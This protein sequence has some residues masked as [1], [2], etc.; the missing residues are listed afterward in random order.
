MK[1]GGNDKALEALKG[2][3][4]RDAKSKYTSRQMTAYKER[5]NRLVQEDA[6]KYPNELVLEGFE[7]HSVQSAAP[8]PEPAQDDFFADWGTDPALRA[9]T[10]SARPSTSHAASGGPLRFAAPG[11]SVDGTSVGFAKH[12][13]SANGFG[14]KPKKPEPSPMEMHEASHGWNAGAASSG[15]DHDARS[16]SHFQPEAKRVS[17]SMAPV[18]AAAPVPG[19]FKK[20]GG[21]KK[22]SKA[23][24][25][26]E[27]AR[28]AEREAER[29]AQ[30]KELEKVRAKS[31]TTSASP[32]VSQQAPSNSFA[33]TSKFGSDRGFQTKPPASAEPPVQEFK[34][35]GFGFD[36][37]AEPPKAEAK[38]TGFGSIPSSES[39]A[40]A[41]FGSAKSISSDQYFGRGAYDANANAEARAKLAQFEGRSGF[42]SA[43][44]Y[45]EEEPLA[46]GRRASVEQ[47]LGAVQDGAADFAAKFAGQA[48]EDFENL[49]KLVT[50]GGS[51]LGDLLSDIQNRYGGN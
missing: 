19:G 5:L 22:I 23:I 46:T 20:K 44:Y 18:Q 11:A 45:G 8:T 34:K 39:S 27:A 6:R 47:A 36:P 50:I 30:E 32:Y 16:A 2:V 43:D 51:K 3:E 1:L 24:D 7:D 33:P 42:G 10:S 13:H 14:D 12:P 31:S 40:N 26:E 28:Q 29:V 25:F 4:F 48:Q 35:F 49:K 9:S 15:W 21:A 37:T 38:V 41:K 17:I